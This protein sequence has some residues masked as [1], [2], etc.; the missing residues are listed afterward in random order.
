MTN[1]LP[2]KITITETYERELDLSN[3]K[4]AVVNPCDDTVYSL[5]KWRD[6]AE[7]YVKKYAHSYSIVDLRPE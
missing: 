6:R 5:F 3:L 7:A 1:T 4:Y 2:S